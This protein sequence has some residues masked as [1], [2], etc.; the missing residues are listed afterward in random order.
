MDKELVM[1]SRTLGCPYIAIAKK[2]LSKYNVSFREIFIDKDDKARQYVLSWTG[3]LSVPTL[4][5]ANAGN[6]LP[7]QAPAP[8]E[9]GQSPR[10]INR[11][12]IITEASRDEL[13]EWLAQHKF[14]TR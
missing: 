4:I 8:L 11:G 5:V 3:F 14:L 6:K 10:G 2:T 13:I 12:T 7:Y 9:K 1:Y